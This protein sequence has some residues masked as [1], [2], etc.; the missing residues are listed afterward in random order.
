MHNGLQAVT[1]ATTY[2]ND[3]CTLDEKVMELVSRML[4]K[5]LLLMPKVY[6]REGLL[7]QYEKEGLVVVEKGLDAVP[8]ELLRVTV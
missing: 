4:E 2:C 3:S 1:T 6:C 5:V 8:L 7:V